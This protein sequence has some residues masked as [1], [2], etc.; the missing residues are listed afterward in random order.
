MVLKQKK[1]TLGKIIDFTYAIDGIIIALCILVLIGYGLYLLI[2]YIR[3]KT[4]NYA[5]YFTCTM[6]LNDIDPKLVSEYMKY[7]N[8]SIPNGSCKNA[9]LKIVV[10]TCA[11]DE[12]GVQS[13]N[14]KAN[15]NVVSSKGNPI[16]YSPTG[17]TFEDITKFFGVSV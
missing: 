3:S 11:V 5:D 7:D 2:M 4:E 12:N 15:A 13:P 14:C 17:T 8:K 9:T 10:N 6:T 1:T 16:S